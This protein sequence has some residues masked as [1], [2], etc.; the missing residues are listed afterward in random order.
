[1]T[2]TVEKQVYSVNDIMV[3]LGIGRTKAY[4]LVNSNCFRTLKVGDK[5][6]SLKK[7]L[8]YG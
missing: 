1:M 6:L 4:E 3:L 8:I 2:A 5:L 7:A